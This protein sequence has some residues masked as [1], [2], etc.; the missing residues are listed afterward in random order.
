MQ[1]PGPHIMLPLAGPFWTAL[2]ATVLLWPQHFRN[3]FGD[4]LHEEGLSSSAVFCKNFLV[5][6]G[7][8]GACEASEGPTK[9][10]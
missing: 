1:R 9:G 7:K 5:L 10:I 6:R 4:L 8:V 3:I 2:E